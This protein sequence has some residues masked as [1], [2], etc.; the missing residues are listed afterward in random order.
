MFIVSDMETLP[1]GLWPLTTR[2]GG[3][4]LISNDNHASMMG[5]SYN[6]DGLLSLTN[7][8]CMII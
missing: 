1:L 4:N 3:L 2:T 7:K 8:Q 6:N 5:I